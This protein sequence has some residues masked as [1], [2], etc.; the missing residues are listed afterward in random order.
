MRLASALL[1]LLLQACWA[2]A[3]D[4]T[5]AVRTVAFQGEWTRRIWDS[6]PFTAQETGPGQTCPAGTPEWDLGPFP[7]R[8]MGAL[9]LLEIPRLG[10]QLPG[11]P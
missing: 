8:V 5:A 7:R 4:D 10:S 9:G 2:A 11:P 1:L 3:Q 6:A